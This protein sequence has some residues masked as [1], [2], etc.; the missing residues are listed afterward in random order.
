MTWFHLHSKEVS[1]TLCYT[2]LLGVD[3]IVEIIKGLRGVVGGLPDALGEGQ[4]LREVGKCSRIC[5][6]VFWID[7]DRMLHSGVASDENKGDK[8]CDM[9][10]TCTLK[11]EDPKFH[12]YKAKNLP[13]LRENVFGVWGG[14]WILQRCLP[15]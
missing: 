15:C 11:Y 8:V 12:G 14:E 10:H 1:S 9:S 7:R 5:M 2:K 13:E 4:S 3:W 6:E